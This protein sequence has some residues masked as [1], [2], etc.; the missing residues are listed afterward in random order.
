ML[1]E[2]LAEFFKDLGYVLKKVF[3][4][5]IVP[6]AL[7]GV[8]LFS[9]LIIRLF[10][11]QIVH[12][13]DYTNSY[14][15]KAEKTIT[16]TGTR[17]NIYDTNGKLLAYSEL[18][19][20]VVIEDSG[21]YESTS[22]KHAAVNA[23]IAKMI[24]IIEENGDTIDYD[25]SLNCDEDGNYYY[26]VSDNALL[27][28]LR[29]VYGR[30]A[31]SDLK[32]EE[33]NATAAD[34][35]EM[36]RNRY[37]IMTA[38]DV[39]K[40]KETEAAA[41]EKDPKQKLTDYDSLTVY[42]DVMAMKIAYIRYNLAANS[43]K[44]YVS[45]TVASN[46]NSYTMAAILEN[47][48]VLTGVSIAEDTI[49]KYNYG[50]YI[51]HIVGYTGK[52]SSDQLE[53]LQAIDSTYEASDVVG[54]SG[55]EQEYETT[56]AGNKGEITMLVDNVGRVLEVT[57]EIEATAGRDIYLTIDI[58][59]QKKVYDL[60][61]RRL[62]EIVVSYLTPSD[63]PFK[64]DGQ[65][66]IPIKDVYFALINNNLIDMEQIEKSDTEAAK[67]TYAM[68]S[69]QKENVL[70]AISDDLAGGIPYGSH[71]DEMKSYLKLVRQ[72]LIDNGILNS[73]KITS[74]DEL[75]QNWTAGNIS[76]RQYLEG[77][78]NNQWIN[79]YNLDIS[80][81]YT[82]TDEVLDCVIDYANTLI[83][84]SRDFDKLIYE[85]LIDSNILSGREVCLILMEQDAIN[86]TETEYINIYNGGS[87]F[88]FL[89]KKIANLDITPAQLALDP[90]SGSCVV[91]DPNSGAILAMVSYPSYD[92]NY[93]SGTIDPAYYSKLL[94]DKST[95]LV[96][97]ATQTKIAPGSTFK[98]L[99]A[100]AGL[101]EGVITSEENVNC[102]G[103]FDKITPNI[104]CWINPGQ[105]GYV[106]TES[107]L[108][109]SC[110]EYFCEIGYRLCFTTSGEM[111][112]DYGLAR[113]KQYAELLGLATKTGI[114]LPETTPRASDYNAV[115]S[116]IGQGTNAYTSLNLARYA[117]TI[118]NSGTVYNSSIV[119]RISNPDGSE[120]EFVNPAIANTVD[121]D[122]S[123]WTTVHNGMKRVISAGVLDP[124]TSQLPADI[125][126][127]SGTAQEDKTRGD[128]ACYILF[129]TGES[130]NAEIVTSV[131]IPYGHSATHAGVMAYYAMASY[132]DYELP[133]SIIFT[134]AGTFEITE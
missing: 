117:S 32:E 70:A 86:Y 108:E 16:T 100:I 65:I 110:N 79:I 87:T 26:N 3:A 84:E 33:R 54:K 39:E 106:N 134:T 74:T 22:A 21:V 128:H 81:D 47:E 1:K 24:T 71:S 91:E 111:S 75:T 73:E 123:I 64:E 112:F 90:C 42:D 12:G 82:T 109:E 115:A 36:L 132:Y 37:K 96:N 56:L 120:V 131:M 83:S 30:S 52:V 72:L 97:R 53:E 19:Y 55:I 113:E 69:S 2:S 9:V 103:L 61:E 118:A 78:I 46:I 76:L 60:L 77:A 68:F 4:S 44:R 80:A 62:A 17:G 10:N 48:D 8:V 29:D 133:S 89:E 104:K 122:P 130:G 98:P 57:N 40:L 88:D 14:I 102:D 95:P 67:S 93:F 7:L 85:Y 129:S 121:I 31:I 20:S 23:V 101:A 99:M 13:D 119:S 126:G 38:G 114:Q 15:M 124:L 50:T 43:Y 107:A 34:T 59:L 127:K 105:H 35:A 125:Y 18:A 51:A 63:S 92:I 5:R 41:K 11:M 6:V 66:L 94:D 25:F 27:R 28:F 49:R 45:F 116:A 58:D